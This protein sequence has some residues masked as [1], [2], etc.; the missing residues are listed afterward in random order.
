MQCTASSQYI[1]IAIVL[2]ARGTFYYIEKDASELFAAPTA[3]Y[4]DLF[5]NTSYYYPQI[6]TEPFA[7]AY[8]QN[9]IFTTTQTPFNPT[10]IVNPS[11]FQDP[12]KHT[13]GNIGGDPDKNFL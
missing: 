5:P 11:Y 4:I 13:F 9:Q 7:S 3:A 12:S 2:F 10:T 1:L 6:S 8:P